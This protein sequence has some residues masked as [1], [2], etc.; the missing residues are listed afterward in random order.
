MRVWFR[1]CCFSLL[2][3]TVSEDHT[4]FSELFMALDGAIPQMIDPLTRR[5]VTQSRY[6]SNI[7]QQLSGVRMSCDAYLRGFEL[8][9]HQ[10]RVPPV[11]QPAQHVWGLCRPMSWRKSPWSL[12]LRCT[13][14]NVLVEYP[15]RNCKQLNSFAGS[16]RVALEI[17]PAHLYTL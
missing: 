13:A 7:S 6:L 3:S 10:P 4:C 15:V 8:N 17:K 12:M 9:L 2:V 11:A 1:T 16:C 14:S 5:F